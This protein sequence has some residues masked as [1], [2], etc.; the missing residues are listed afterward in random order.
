MKDWLRPP[1]IHFLVKSAGH[2]QLIT[3]SYFHPESLKNGETINPEFIPESN[4]NPPN[5]P[6]LPPSGPSFLK[7]V[8]DNDRILMDL[9]QAQRDKLFVKFK[10]NGKRVGVFNLYLDP[11]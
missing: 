2:K 7:H 8:N 10:T 1:H 3:Q 11:V 6:P 4:K 9:T 5:Q